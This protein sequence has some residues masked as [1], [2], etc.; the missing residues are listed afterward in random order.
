MTEQ[1]RAGCIQTCATPDSEVNL[2]NAAAAIR[3]VSAKGGDLALLPEAFDCLV[4]TVAEM[5]AYAPAEADHPAVLMLD[6]LARELGLWI[7]AGSISVRTEAGQ[8]ANR[9]IL[10]APTGIAARYDKIHLFDVDL[11]DGGSM[12]ESDFYSRGD[13]AVVASTPWG[14]LG[15]S[16]C[17]DLRFP[18]LHRA[19]AMHGASIIAIPAAF[20]SVTGP[21]HWEPLLRARAIETGCFVLAPAQ[22]G[23]HYGE[24][25][26]HGRSM[27]IDP[28]GRILEVAG[29]EPAILMADLDLRQVAQFRSAI[30]SLANG[31][32]FTITGAVA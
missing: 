22:C 9:S 6:G 18:Q 7:L 14:G 16:I 15:L 29:G 21:L 17:Y 32:P 25:R 1:M 19:L 13:R 31:Q 10:F 4:P 27:I 30:P 8:L 3:E 11:P 23:L 26:S 2:A 24:R 12:R 20:S 28:W 5:R